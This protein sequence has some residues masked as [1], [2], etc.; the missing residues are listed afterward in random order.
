M[1]V[2]MCAI[3]ECVEAGVVVV[4]VVKMVVM[5]IVVVV[6]VVVMESAGACV[7]GSRKGVVWRYASSQVAKSKLKQRQR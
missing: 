3:S 2:G 6:V 4:V 7:L 1:S 5:V